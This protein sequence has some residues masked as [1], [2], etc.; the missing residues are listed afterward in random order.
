MTGSERH[1]AVFLDRDGVLVR[2]DVRDGKPYA[3]STLAEFE[4]LPDALE[5]TK[6]LK[7]SGFLLVV[8]TNQPDVGNGLVER[9]VVEAMHNR[10]R[11]ALPIDDIRVCYHAQTDACACRKPKPGM[12]LEAAA[13]FGIN[14]AN[15]VMIGDRWNDIVAGHGAGCYTILIDRE[16]VESLPI[17]PDERVGS[18]AEA[19]SVIVRRKTAGF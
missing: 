16:Y 15:S 10:L 4:I 18:L 3:A 12:L 19:A 14:L 17:A 7:D 2:T 9:A 6:I 5:S 8:V 1:A 13:R 11:A